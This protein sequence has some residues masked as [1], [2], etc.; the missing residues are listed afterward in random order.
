MKQ[1]CLTSEISHQLR[2]TADFISLRLSYNGIKP[3]MMWDMLGQSPYAGLRQVGQTSSRMCCAKSRGF[4]LL[5]LLEPVPL[6]SYKYNTV[7]VHV[8]VSPVA[9]HSL[10][11]VARSAVSRSRHFTPSLVDEIVGARTS[12]RI[13]CPVHPLL[14]SAL[15]SS[16]MGITPAP[17]SRSEAWRTKDESFS[18][19][20]YLISLKTLRHLYSSACFHI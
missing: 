2:S 13:L 15:I 5:K 17:D 11:R 18:A 9:V 19:T 7:R 14:L 20:A 4:V 10:S 8:M 12:S 16:P 3:S 1:S 6:C